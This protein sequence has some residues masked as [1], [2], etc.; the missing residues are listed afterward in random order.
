MNR[1]RRNLLAASA[2][3][4]LA[5]PSI[6]ASAAERM[7]VAAVVGIGPADAWSAAFRESLREL[8]WVDGTTVR[9]IWKSGTNEMLPDMLDEAVR[10]PVDVMVVRSSYVAIAAMKKTRRI[11]IVV[12]N[13]FYPVGAGLAASLSRPGGN[14]T[15]RANNAGGIEINGKQLALLKEVA[16]GVTKVAYLTSPLAL[17]EDQFA[18]GGVDAAGIPNRTVAAGRAVGI[19]LMRVEIDHRTRLEEA[20][21]DAIRRGANGL[22]VDTPRE[23]RVLVTAAQRYKLPT[24]Y[25]YEAGVEA[26][27]L[28]YYGPSERDTARQ[29]AA[30]VD[31]ILRGAKPAELPFEAPSKMELTVNLKA[32][33][34]IGLV[35]PPSV[36]IQAD[37]VI[38]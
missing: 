9:I 1:S 23:P 15:G 3:L 19:A 22:M 6:E 31:R 29:A 30:F 35:I 28:M 12:A 16:P 33:K 37:R 18:E 21:E 24:V 38:Q 17:N 4:A 7:P 10:T 14:V 26:G 11:P 8:G 32:A 34:A 25:T 2:G 27:G 36:L 13:S 20:V 5:S